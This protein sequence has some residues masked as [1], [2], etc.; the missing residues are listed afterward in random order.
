MH[1]VIKQAHNVLCVM[2][3]G[4]LVEQFED[5]NLDA[6]LLKVGSLVFD[7]LGSVGIKVRAWWWG[8]ASMRGVINK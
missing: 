6:R 7:D 5:G 3:V 2:W 8:C 4:A 1:K